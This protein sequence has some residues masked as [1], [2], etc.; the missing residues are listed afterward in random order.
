M[1]TLNKHVKS[2][3]VKWALTAI[4]LILLIGAVVGLSVIL[5]RNIRTKTLLSVDYEIGAISAT[6]EAEESKVAI[7]MKNLEKVDGMEIELAKDA[8]VTY[9]VF[10]YDADEAFLS[11][12]GS[13]SA[14]LKNP[15]VENAE[16]FKIV[17]YTA[18]EA[19]VNVFGIV[20]LASQLT[21]TVQK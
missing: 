7:R 20:G 1:S 21:V 13:L 2:D 12:S 14:S 3:K 18:E 6:G 5:N 11:K 15:T 17:I 16:Y 9:E 4:V 8:E 10:Y 19:E